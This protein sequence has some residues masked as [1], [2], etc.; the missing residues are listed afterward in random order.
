VTGRE[1]QTRS[2]VRST[3]RSFSISINWS[4]NS[5]LKTNSW[6]RRWSRL[7][8]SS[9]RSRD[10]LIRRSSGSRIWGLSRKT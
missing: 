10:S 7:R 8:A 5:L 3:W 1:A 9:G 6:G 2:W 4:R